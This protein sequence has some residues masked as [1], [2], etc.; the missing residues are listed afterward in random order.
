MPFLLQHQQDRAA[1]RF[2]IS[3]S[4][5]RD[6]EKSGS[7]R[8]ISL[9]RMVGGRQNSLHRLPTKPQS[10]PKHLSCAVS[11]RPSHLLLF[12]SHQP[13]QKNTFFSHCWIFPP[14]G[15]ALEG[16]H[17]AEKPQQE[18]TSCFWQTRLSCTSDGSLHHSRGYLP[19][20]CLPTAQDPRPSATLVD[21]CK[22]WLF[23]RFLD[24]LTIP[25]PSSSLPPS[26]KVFPA[27]PKIS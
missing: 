7:S 2:H 19:P 25:P 13:W 8:G 12:A 10:H 17:T 21:L 20:C 26:S 9:T 15:S 18:V 14:S 24:A 4:A 11:N 6:T 1:K 16:L 3:T 27:C 5:H 22:R 23:R